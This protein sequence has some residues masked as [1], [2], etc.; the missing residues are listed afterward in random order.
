MNHHHVDLQATWQLLTF[1]KVQDGPA[2]R[3]VLWQPAGCIPA[4]AGRSLSCG[5]LRPQGEPSA[6]VHKVALVEIPMREGGGVVQR[7][8]KVLQA[9]QARLGRVLC[10]QGVPQAA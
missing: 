8:C 7:Q 1:W 9:W 4:A 10:E 2:L 6:H 3:A 5:R